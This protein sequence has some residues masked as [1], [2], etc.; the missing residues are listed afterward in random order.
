MTRIDWYFGVLIFVIV[1]V[2][3]IGCLVGIG[4]I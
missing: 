1:V 4:V 3:V 2:V